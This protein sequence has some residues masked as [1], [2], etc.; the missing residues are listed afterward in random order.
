MAEIMQKDGTW[1]FEGDSVRLVP[2]SDKGVSLLRR[3]L[4][5]IT[6][7][8][9]AVAGIFFEPGK[10]TGRLRL[11]LREGACPLM[12]IA[13]GRLDDSSDPYR[14]VVENDRTGVAEYF[15]DEVRNAL[16]LDQIGSGPVDRYL[17]GGPVLPYTAGAGD[18]SVTVDER[19]VRLTWTWT[20]ET[21]KSSGGPRTIPLAEVMAVEWLP[22]VGLEHGYLRFVTSAAGH[23]MPPKYDPHA[24]HLYGL[25]K[26]PLM[27]LAAAAVVAR[28]PHPHAREEPED[29]VPAALEAAPR[30]AAP[31]AEDHDVLLR[32]LRE[33]GELHQAK[34]LTDEEFAM[35][36]QAV[37]KRL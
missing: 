30:D 25:K 14:L 13:G 32:R 5:E 26:D 24:V 10:K 8:L 37:L 18:A 11:R 16:L 4:G 23:T 36:K 31:A 1:S 2:G 33:L 21:S 7:P 34:I 35:A 22:A 17:L 28:M 29:A 12:Q 20:T 6:V 27:A 9:E 19:Q 15:V 3:T